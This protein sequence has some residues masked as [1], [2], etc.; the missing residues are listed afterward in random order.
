[1][2]FSSVRS[3][4]CRNV[5]EKAILSWVKIWPMYTEFSLW[6]LRLDDKTKAAKVPV[7]WIKEDAVING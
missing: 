6:L 7:I 3:E 5:F 4:L 2:L 1:M